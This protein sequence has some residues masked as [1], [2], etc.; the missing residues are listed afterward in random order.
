MQL[1]NLI[2]FHNFIISLFHYFISC[3]FIL[4]ILFAADCVVVRVPD[5]SSRRTAEVREQEQDPAEG[6]CYEQVQGSTGTRSSTRT[7][8]TQATSSYVLEEEGDGR[9]DVE[10]VEVEEGQGEALT[11]F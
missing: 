10:A 11:M 5:S 6:S 8:Q 3:Y 9:G 2:P 4:F 1:A 7:T